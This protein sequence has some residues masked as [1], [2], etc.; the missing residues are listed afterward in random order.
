MKLKTA[1][2][3]VLICLVLSTAVAILNLILP[4]EVMRSIYQ[5]NLPALLHIARDI[6]LMI[7]FFVLLKNQKREQP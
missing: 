3:A 2:I 7:F 1:T 6:A 4:P 5:S